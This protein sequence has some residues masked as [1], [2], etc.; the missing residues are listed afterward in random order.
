VLENDMAVTFDV[1]IILD[2]RSRLREQPFE[3]R[4]ADMQWLRP[5][6]LTVE[7]E[8]IKS[9]EECLVVVLPAMQ[10][11]EDGEAARVATDRLAVDG[12]RGGPQRTGGLGRGGLQEGRPAAGGGSPARGARKRL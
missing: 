12:D 10:L 5:I 8:Q 4:L 1:L 2:A 7:I 3:S 9:I 11:F 6:V